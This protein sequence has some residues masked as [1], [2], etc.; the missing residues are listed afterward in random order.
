[1]EVIRYL[2]GETL[3]AGGLLSEG[4]GKGWGLVL[5]DGFSLGWC[6][7]AGGMIKNHYPKGLR[8]M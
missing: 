5:T 1:M 2:K 4:I 8:W 6:K 7:M 3:S